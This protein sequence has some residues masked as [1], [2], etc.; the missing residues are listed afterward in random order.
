[1]AVLTE[2]LRYRH[3]IL[4]DAIVSEELEPGT[5]LVYSREELSR[6]S[7]GAYPHGMNL[8]E[9]LLLSENL[10]VSLTEKMVLIGVAVRGAFVFGEVMDEALETG[11]D[12]ILARVRGAA[13]G[14]LQ[15]WDDKD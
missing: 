1:M 15:E 10:A 12:G 9:I 11:F 13:D 7:R 6:V 2:L 4:V 5:V 8:P 3:I 14:Q